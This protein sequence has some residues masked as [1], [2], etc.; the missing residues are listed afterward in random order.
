MVLLPLFRVTGA[1][2][3]CQPFSQSPLGRVGEVL[4]A[5]WLA[6]G[7]AVDRQRRIGVL[8]RDAVAH[9]QPVIARA[10]GIHRPL[11]L[12]PDLIE[13]ADIRTARR[14]RA[15]HVLGRGR[16]A[17]QPQAAR[18]L[19][20][21]L[22]GSGL[23]GLV[24]GGRLSPAVGPG[25]PAVSSLAFLPLVSIATPMP[26]HTTATT[27]TAPISRPLRPR[28]GSWPPLPGA[29]A[30]RVRSPPGSVSGAA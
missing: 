11:H 8:A 9:V 27:A 25:L 12:R 6:V 17:V 30:E 24:A 15:R 13:A 23:L 19:L 21:Q 7:L 28:R 20:G 10:R 22:A 29:G 2:V 16:P 18:V 4:Q 3:V 26:M 14:A 1:Q 5:D